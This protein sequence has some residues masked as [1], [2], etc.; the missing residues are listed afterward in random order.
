MKLELII[1]FFK[2]LFGISEY[3]PPELVIQPKKPE[4][5]SPHKKLY[6]HARTFLGKDASPNDIATDEYGCAE[7]ITD[8]IHSCFND[9]PTEGGTI[10][11]TIILYK[12][13]K[14]H[15][16]FNMVTNFGPGDVLVSPTGYGNGTIKNGHT[17]IV[18]ENGTIMSNNSETGLF[19]ENYTV[20]SW[21]AKF[22]RQGGFP[23]YFFRRIEL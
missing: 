3:K 16:K 9:F 14:A 23:L 8:I 4:Q 21:V 19:E 15:K 18:G 6:E 10:I 13:L 22:R 17:G 5:V 1:S 12:R 2:K 20:D 7:T 11:S